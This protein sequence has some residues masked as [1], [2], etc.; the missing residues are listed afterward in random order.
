MIGSPLLSVDAVTLQYRVPGRLVTA[1]HDVSF[2]VLSGDR[3]V[4][5]G[6]S[7]CG[8]SSLLK[9]I[10]GF[11]L[12]SAGTI[13][14][15]GEPVRRPGPDRMMVFQDL[16]QLLP[17]QTVAGNV[18]SALRRAAGLPR[19]EAEVRA[20][21]MIGRV[22]LAKFAEAYP[23]TLS[24]GMKQRAALARALALRPAMLLM[25]EPF[26]ALDALTRATMQ[27]ELLGLS[28]DMALTVLFVTHSVEEALLI[29][30]RI[31]VLSAHPGQVRA[32]FN[33]VPPDAAPAARERL[34]QRIE[35]LIMAT[36]AS[37][38]EISHGG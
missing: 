10:A 28:L 19:Q 4:I 25:D 14:L 11:A 15:A 8:K 32:E 7:G 1:V 18:V 27:R 2:D 9:A 20:T 3:F 13:R 23:H 36:D 34:K 31:L 16:D 24:G 29:G 12:P 17:W 26:A 21:E 33:G 35:T 22:G 38:A 30:T 6:P 5:L 37:V